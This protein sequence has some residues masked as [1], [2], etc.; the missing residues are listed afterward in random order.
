LARQTADAEAEARDLGALARSRKLQADRA[1]AVD[2]YR[3]ALHVAYQIED[4]DLQAEYAFELGNLLSDDMNMLNLALQ[5]LR[6]SDAQ[7]PNGE[8]R[9]M[10]ERARKRLERATA[11]SVSVPDASM[12]S[13]DYAAEAYKAHVT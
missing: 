7:V 6:E 2:Y 12:S 11:A 8:A 13:Q 10:V 1:G 3:Q 9:R 4:T 5:L